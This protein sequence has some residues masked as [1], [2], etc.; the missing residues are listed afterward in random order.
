MHSF[1][2]GIVFCSS[3]LIS[4]NVVV[5]NQ[6]VTHRNRAAYCRDLGRML[7]E[8]RSLQYDS[9][10]LTHIS[11]QVMKNTQLDGIVFCGEYDTANIIHRRTPVHLP[12]R[13]FCGGKGT[14]IILSDADIDKTCSTIISALSRS[15]GSI[16][17]RL[18]L[19]SSFRNPS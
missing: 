9:R 1:F 8:E 2:Y 15:G 5:T 13:L 3:A 6:V 7:F 18:C 12:L 10:V 4:G 11:Q 19:V 17:I 16:S 14:G